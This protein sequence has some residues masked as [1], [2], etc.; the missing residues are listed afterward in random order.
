[1][2]G[3]LR[4]PSSPIELAIA[5]TLLAYE[6]DEVALGLWERSVYLAA[7]GFIYQIA[8]TSERGGLDKTVVGKRSVGE[9]LRWVDG[10]FRPGGVPGEENGIHFRAARK[11]RE[12]I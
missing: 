7:D 3:K 12:L 8:V 2:S 4:N 1:M 10:L 9:Y 5:G 6:G 11:L